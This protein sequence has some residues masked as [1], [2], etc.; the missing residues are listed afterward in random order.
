MI[1]RQAEAPIDVGLDGMLRIAVVPHVRA[2]LDRAELGRRAVLVG[3]ADE[4]HLVSDLAAET[5]MHIGGQKRADEIAEVLD[6]VDVGQRAGDQ[7]FAHDTSVCVRGAEPEKQKPFRTGGRA[8]VLGACL[9]RS[10]ARQPFRTD[11]SRS[12]RRIRVAW[13]NGVRVMV[14][15]QRC[16]SGRG[17]AVPCIIPAPGP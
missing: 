4:Q 17:S 13:M 3:A 1:E 2:G 12:G 8:R 5:R 11:L 9:A 7:N 16:W 10:D 14:C 6:P 15:S